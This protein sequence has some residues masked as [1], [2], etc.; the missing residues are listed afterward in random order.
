MNGTRLLLSCC[1]CVSEHSSI[2]VVVAA[3]SVQCQT[4]F[5][6]FYG[7]KWVEENRLDEK[8]FSKFSRPYW[9]NP[10]TKST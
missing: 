1:L 7:Q 5:V 2:A 8:Y 4:R 3:A 6:V 9:G 10:K